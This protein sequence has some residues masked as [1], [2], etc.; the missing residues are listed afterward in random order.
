YSVRELRGASHPG[1]LTE[2]PEIDVDFV[3][4]LEPEETPGSG[5]AARWARDGRVGDTMSMLGPNKH[6]VGADYGGIEVRPAGVGAG[7]LPGDDT[8]LTA[9]CSIL[10]DMPASL[11]GHAVIEVL[12]ATG[13]QQVLTRS[14]VQIT[15]LTRGQAPHVHLMIA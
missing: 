9:I 7:M 6:L 4:H 1:N 11:G 14:G 2:H 10:K 5:V 3:L 8:A 13:L 12:D 15:W